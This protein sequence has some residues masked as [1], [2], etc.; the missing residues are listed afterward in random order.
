MNVKARRESGRPR[1]SID[2]KYHPL[3]LNLPRVR[4]VHARTVA[5]DII[6]VV[7]LQYERQS[8]KRVRRGTETP[9]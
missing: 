6:P 2:S 8:Q 5:L 3:F 7:P 1:R 9:R 4:R